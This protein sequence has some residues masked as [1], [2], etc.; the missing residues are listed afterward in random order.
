MPKPRSRAHPE[1]VAQAEKQH[2]A[3]QM[4]KAGYTLA[5]IAKKLG[6]AGKQGASEI[7][8]TALQ[9]LVHVP[10]EEVRQLQ[11]ARLDLW[12]TKLE[13]KINKGD[14]KAIQTAL[15]IEERRAR[16]MGLDAP[17]KV[18]DPNGRPVSFVVMIPQPAPTLEDWQAQAREVIDVTPE[19]PET[20]NGTE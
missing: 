9:Q 12:L 17:V 16:L 6:Y 1:V 14:P 7:I 8:K 4:V 13:K 15:R 18:A 19:P 20:R 2:Q 5:E 11:L 3:L 10:A